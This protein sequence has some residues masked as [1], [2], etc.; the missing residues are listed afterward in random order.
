M[1]ARNAGHEIQ[2]DTAASQNVVNQNVQGAHDALL[3]PAMPSEQPGHSAVDPAGPSAS[4]AKNYDSTQH[5]AASPVVIGEA[6]DLERTSI[7]GGIDVHH[8]TLGG[9]RP[10]PVAQNMPDED[11]RVYR[12]Y[13]QHNLD[14]D[15]SRTQSRFGALDIN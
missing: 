7:D 3:K 15:D 5:D 4:P 8:L 1:R 11:G 6:L 13:L 9:K 12:T 10:T 14:L 2:G